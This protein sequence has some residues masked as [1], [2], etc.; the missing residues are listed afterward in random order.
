MQQG[1]DEPAVPTK[2]SGQWRKE[3]RGAAAGRQGGRHLGL[4]E[5]LSSSMSALAQLSSPSES[6]FP[7]GPTPSG[8]ALTH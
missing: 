7:L 2:Q 8:T 3:G 5:L 6:K 1:L 4:L